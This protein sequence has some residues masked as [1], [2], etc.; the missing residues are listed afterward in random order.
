RNLE[1]VSSQNFKNK[2]H[3]IIDN[4][5]NDGTEDLIKNY[6]TNVTYPVIY[7]REKDFG[8]YNAMNKGIRIA[9]GDWI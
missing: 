7:I 5:S 2:E 6:K 9:K 4:L 1:S 3:I 8:I